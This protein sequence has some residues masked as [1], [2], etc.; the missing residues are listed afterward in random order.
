MLSVIGM[1]LTCLKR[2]GRGESR[3][4]FLRGHQRLP[5]RV[6]VGKV[7]L[8]I[9]GQPIQIIGERYTILDF[10]NATVMIRVNLN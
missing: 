5:R 8:W 3:L 7:F 6:A 1:V 2:N 4:P 10:M 9:D